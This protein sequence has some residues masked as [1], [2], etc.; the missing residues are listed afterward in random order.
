[1]VSDD[2]KVW[3]KLIDSEMEELQPAKNTWTTM[4]SVGLA[5]ENLHSMFTQNFKGRKL[6]QSMKALVYRKVL[7][8][9]FLL[10][11]QRYF[12][13]LLESFYHFGAFGR[14][15]PMVTQRYSLKVQQM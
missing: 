4:E 7:L 13:Y 1:M 11:P 15:K 10:H 12:V 9:D 14:V 8:L 5:M 3:T 6:S 2:S